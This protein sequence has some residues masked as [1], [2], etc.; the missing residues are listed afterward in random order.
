MMRKRITIIGVAILSIIALIA[1]ARLY[2]PEHH[3]WKWTCA[4]LAETEA[5][6]NNLG[7]VLRLYEVDNGNYPERLDDLI[8]NRTSA[9]TWRGPYL[10]NGI[11]QDSWGNSFIYAAQPANSPTQFFLISPGPDRKQGTKDDI[12]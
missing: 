10:T 3:C 8:T 7:L 12:K 6:I 11:P 2:C 9:S 4:Q 1:L 5:E